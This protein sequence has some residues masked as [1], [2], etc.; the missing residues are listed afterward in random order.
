MSVLD[1]DVFLTYRGVV[2]ILRQPQSILVLFG[3]LLT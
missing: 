3:I 2:S 1:L